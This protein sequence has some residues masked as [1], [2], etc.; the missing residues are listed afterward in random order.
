VEIKQLTDDKRADFVF[1]VRLD[2][3]H[4]YTTWFSSNYY[5]KLTGGKITPDE[6]VKKSFEFLL[7]HESPS[8]ILPEFDLSVISRY[9][10][11]YEDTLR[12]GLT[13]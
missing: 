4:E 7:A 3:G 6:L 2:D 8:S 11:D 5:Q 10:P 12:K 13:A 9:F 1:E